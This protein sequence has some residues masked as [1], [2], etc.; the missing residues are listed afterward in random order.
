MRLNDFTRKYVLHRPL[1]FGI[2]I[3]LDDIG[4]K[5]SVESIFNASQTGYVTS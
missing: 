4:R 1:T 3:K 5:S 2:Q